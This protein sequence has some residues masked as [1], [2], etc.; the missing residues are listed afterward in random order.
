MVL[1]VRDRVLRDASIE[2]EHRMTAPHE[3]VREMKSDEPG[4]SRDEDSQGASSAPDP[5]I[6]APIYVVIGNGRMQARRCRTDGQVDHCMDLSP[7]PGDDPM[8][9]LLARRPT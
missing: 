9:A 8:S 5:T 1:D 3:Q 7:V 6:D 2:S 4:V